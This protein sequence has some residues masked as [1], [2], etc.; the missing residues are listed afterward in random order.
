MLQIQDL[1]VTGDYAVRDPEGYFWTL[2]RADEVLKI[3]GHRI[4]SLELENAALSHPAMA[5]AAAVE[6]ADPIKGEAIVIFAIL[7][8][9][10]KSS[11]SSEKRAK[12]AFPPCGGTSGPPRRYTSWT[13]CP[14]PGVVRS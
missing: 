9:G 5:E 10:L 12:R 6:R 3:A 4:G 2:G 1:D 8:E 14:K 11:P 13:N 7:R